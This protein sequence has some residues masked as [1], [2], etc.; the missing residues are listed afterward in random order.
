MR[1]GLVAQPAVLVGR[2]EDERHGLI[3]CVAYFDP[4]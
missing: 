4:Q 2:R 1:I 3:I